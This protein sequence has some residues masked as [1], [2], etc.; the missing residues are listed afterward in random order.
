MRKGNS[1]FVGGKDHTT[2]HLSYLGLSEKQV[3]AVI[4]LIAIVSSAIVVYVISNVK[5][6]SHW[7]TAIF[8]AYFLIVFVVLFTIANKNINKSADD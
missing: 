2:H 7:H 5:V 3:A 6:W 8:V 1:P 4:A